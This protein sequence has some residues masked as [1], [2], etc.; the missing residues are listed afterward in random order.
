MLRAMIEMAKMLGLG[1]DQQQQ[2]EAI[3]GQEEAMPGQEDAMAGA[4]AEQ[5]PNQQEGDAPQGEADG[6]PDYG[7]LFPKHPDN[8]GSPQGESEDPKPP[9]QLA[10]R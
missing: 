10:S 6:H 9:G 7:N 2:D 3:P 5:D 8:G 4:S 1:P